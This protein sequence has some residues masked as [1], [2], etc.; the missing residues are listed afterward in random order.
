MTMFDPD[1]VIEQAV[2]Q[3]WKNTRYDRAQGQLVF[4]E[5]WLQ[6]DKYELHV[7]CTTG[8]IGS[9]LDHPRQGPTQ[10]YRRNVS[11]S[12][13]RQIMNN[14]RVHTGT[15]SGRDCLPVLLRTRVYVAALQ[16]LC[17]T[18]FLLAGTGYHERAEL[19]RRRSASQ[20]DTP[21]QK[22]ARTVAC[23]GCG[24]MHFSMGDTAQH[25]ESGR[26]SSC[27]GEDYARRQAYGMARQMGIGNQF[28]VNNNN[29]LTFNDSGQ[30]DHQ[31]G[32]EAGGQNYRC[33]SCQKT[34]GQFSAL[35]NHQQARAQCRGSGH[36]ALGFN[37]Y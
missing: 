4:L 32:Y 28:F 6:D 8:T 3:G 1:E 24:R 37:G 14:P 7:W 35:L 17:W 9:Y 21:P 26:C 13:L 15:R 25:F 5:R 31:A 27:P 22:R 11:W 16:A 23:P 12:E 2:R 30:E 18:A 10:L 20:M 34:F 36:A 29:L 19:E 33:P